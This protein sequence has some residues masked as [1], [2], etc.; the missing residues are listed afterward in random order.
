MQSGLLEQRF[1]SRQGEFVAVF[2]VDAL[3]AF[4]ETLTAA[5]G[6]PLAAQ[7]LQM[8]FDASVF[9]IE[10]RPVFPLGGD[11]IGFGQVVNHVENVPVERGGDAL[12]VIVGRLQNSKAGV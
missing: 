10:K 3:A 6:N 12:G 9:W 11:E 8:H 1:K 2:S 4:K 7:G 5:P